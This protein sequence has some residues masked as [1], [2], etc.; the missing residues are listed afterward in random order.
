[1]ASML[2]ESG[3]EV[4]V[5]AGQSQFLAQL[6]AAIRWPSQSGGCAILWGPL[7]GDACEVDFSH[8]THAVQI[9]LDVEMLFWLCSITMESGL[10]ILQSSWASPASLQRAT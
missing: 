10:T 6:A 5:V 2:C 3:E 7:G 8:V 1:M 4:E 9:V